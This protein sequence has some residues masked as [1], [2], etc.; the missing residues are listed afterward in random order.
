MTLG[1]MIFNMNISPEGL[2]PSVNEHLISLGTYVDTLARESLDNMGYE[3]HNEFDFFDFTQLLLNDYDTFKQ[4]GVSN[5]S[6]VLDKNL[7]IL[8]YVMFE[9]ILSFNTTFSK[10]NKAIQDKSE[11]TAQDVKD[12]MHSRF[13]KTKAIFSISKGTGSI[14]P[15]VL[16]NNY[17]DNKIMRMT[18]LA[19][20]QSRGEGVKKKKSKG[21]KKI[22]LDVETLNAIDLLY[23]N[24]LHLPKSLI[25]PLA[26]L[27]PYAR[28]NDAGELQVPDD[29]KGMLADIEADLQNIGFK[30][31][32]SKELI[33]V[34][35]QNDVT[36]N[37]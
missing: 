2:M 31:D 25:T 36:D 14:L 7:D 28:F 16:A 4:M 24:V 13:M 17:C 3:P 37:E 29:L 35:E 19:E 12:I 5:S 33:N 27:N 10:I 9:I 21:S 11:L 15:L 22:P 18:C 23:G 6:T 30:S 32:V 26:R 8:Y 20:L 1:L 34:M